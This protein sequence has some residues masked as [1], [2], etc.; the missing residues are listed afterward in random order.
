MDVLSLDDVDLALIYLDAIEEAEAE[1][2][3]KR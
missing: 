3:E 1:L 2:N